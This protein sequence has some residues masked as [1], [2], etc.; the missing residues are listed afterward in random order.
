MKKE[1]IVADNVFRSKSLGQ[2]VKA[3]NTVYITGQVARAPDGN[4]VG[5]G[6]FAAQASQTLEN[7]KRIVEAA[8]GSMQDVV[9]STAYFRNIEDLPKYREIRDK[10]FG[11]QHQASST[12]IEISKLAHPQALI[13]VDAIAVID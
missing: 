6:D 11:G 13:E 4:L 9:K 12:A 10:Y 8:G 5:V 7:I 2:A 3:G 1:V